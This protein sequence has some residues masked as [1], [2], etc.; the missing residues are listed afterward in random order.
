HRNGCLWGHDPSTR[1]LAPETIH[2]RAYLNDCT[3]LGGE[4]PPQLDRGVVSR[5]AHCR[6]LWLRGPAPAQRREAGRWQGY[7]APLVHA[8]WRWRPRR[9]YELQIVRSRPSPVLR[10]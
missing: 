1:I 6:S 8:G 5:Y 4:S 7:W 10:R 3:I 9:V 2:D